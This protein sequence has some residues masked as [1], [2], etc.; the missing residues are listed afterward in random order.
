MERDKGVAAEVL[1]SQGSYGG[2]LTQLPSWQ[3]PDHHKSCG[4]SYEEVHEKTQPS[5]LLVTFFAAL[6]AMPVVIRHVSKRQESIGATTQS[7][8]VTARY[9]FHFQ[10]VA[11]AA[12]MTFSHQAPTFDPQLN[13]V[14]PEVAS[15]GAAVSVVDFDRDGLLIRRHQQWRGSQNRLNAT[16]T[17]FPGRA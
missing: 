13:H 11:K 7:E 10:E 2:I 14:M 9:G 15:L 12:G 5:I 8:T 1:D 17:D 4:R 16:C 3:N 6:I